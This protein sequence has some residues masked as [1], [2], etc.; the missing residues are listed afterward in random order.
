MSGGTARILLGG[1]GQVGR[2]VLAAAGSFGIDCLAPPRRALDLADLEAL[3]RFVGEADVGLVVNAAAYTQVDRAEAEPAPCHAVNAVAVA[4]L[5]QAC[6]RRALP[7]IQL[8]TDY[9]FGGARHTPWP[10]TA[11]PAPLNLYG[12]SK[13]AGELAVRALLPRHVLL[14]VSAVFSQAGPGFVQAMVRRAAAAEPARVVADQTTCPTFAGHVAEAVLAIA[15]RH[16]A[17][18]AVPWGT[19][20]LCDAPAVSWH[21]FAAAI[22]AA[23]RR[24]GLPSPPPLAVSS[25]GYAAPARR[26]A[27]SVLGCRRIARAFGIRRRRW[28]APLEQVVTALVREARAG[29]AG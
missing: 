12:V 19:Y 21:G 23:C 5:A 8:S 14:R 3:R 20:H 10:E 9:V 27:Y 18:T 11:P 2:A 7:L 6:A 1:S 13:A 25:A 17:G 16:L 15:A 24:Q 29:A 26:P 4:V 22:L 28:A